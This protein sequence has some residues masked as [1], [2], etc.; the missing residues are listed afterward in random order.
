V[1][2]AGWKRTGVA[3]QLAVAA[4][5]PAVVL[6]VAVLRPA[7]PSPAAET[8]HVKKRPEEQMDPRDG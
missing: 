4:S 8:I 5:L 6:A 1:Q 3:A 2:L 7:A